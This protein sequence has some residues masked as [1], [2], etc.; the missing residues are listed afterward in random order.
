MGC[1]KSKDADT[2]LLQSKESLLGPNDQDELQAVFRL[3]QLEIEPA[4]SNHRLELEEKLAN[5]NHAL[6]ISHQELGA[7]HAAE[8]EEVRAGLDLAL[9]AKQLELDVKLQSKQNEMDELQTR[10]E[11]ALAADDEGQFADSHCCATI[12]YAIV[13]ILFVPVFCSS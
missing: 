11:V 2:Q 10:H 5:H 6:K 7:T 1:C 8:I 3:K 4:A 13:E 9:R 12:A